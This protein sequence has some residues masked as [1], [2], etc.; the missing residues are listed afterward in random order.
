MQLILLIIFSAKNFLYGIPEDLGID[1]ADDFD[2][3]TPKN[4]SS[5]FD[6]TDGKGT[7]KK[8]RRSGRRSSGLTRKSLSRL[9]SHGSNLAY[10]KENDSPTQS[11]FSA[12][13]EYW[14][15]PIGKKSVGLIP[16]MALPLDL[17]PLKQEVEDG[18]TDNE[19]NYPAGSAF[20]A[21]RKS[22]SLN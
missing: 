8:S 18:W 12:L 6:E 17:R 11:H 9:S 22:N 14:T 20:N 7:P 4:R 16:K 15:S 21:V 3:S 1:S 2:G 5:S 10:K 13:D 19:G